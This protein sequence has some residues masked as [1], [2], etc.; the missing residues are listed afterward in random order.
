MK[1][2]SYGHVLSSLRRTDVYK[3][4]AE[5]CGRVVA[6][7]IEASYVETDSKETRKALAGLLD[8][9]GERLRVKTATDV[10]K[11]QRFAR[12]CCRSR[13]N[14]MAVAASSAMMAAVSRMYDGCSA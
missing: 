4:Q 3:R 6:P 10:Y 8:L 2:L 9:S 1:F 7:L 14:G 13:A 12:P 11:R 5:Q